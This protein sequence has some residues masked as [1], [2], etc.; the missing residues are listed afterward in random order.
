MPWLK[1]IAIVLLV[2]LVGIQFVQPDKNNTDMVMANDISTVVTVPDSVHTLLKTAC[3]DCHS[4]QTNYP[5]YT[6]IQPVGWWLADHI[7]EGKSHLNFQTFATLKP[8]PG[9]RFKTV[10][11]LQDH[12]LEEVRESQADKWMPL[13]SYSFIHGDAKL[14]DAQRQMIINWVDSAR[15]QL[16]KL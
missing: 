14:T 3:Y 7:E 6:N 4:N 12:K 10:A 13:E 9:G 1:R 11:A 15:V 8:K 2:T 5:W 16:A